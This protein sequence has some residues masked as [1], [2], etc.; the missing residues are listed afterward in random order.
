MRGK[1]REKVKNKG[2]SVSKG[3]QFK[4][5]NGGGGIYKKVQN[6]I[7]KCYPECII[8]GNSMLRINDQHSREEIS[9]RASPKCIMV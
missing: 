4:A 7:E 1:K 3:R 6:V 5:G 2:D 9:S 8:N